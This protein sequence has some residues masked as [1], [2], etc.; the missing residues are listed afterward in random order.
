MLVRVADNDVV[1]LNESLLQEDEDIVGLECV[2]GDHSVTGAVVFDAEMR[3]LPLVSDYLSYS[4]RYNKISEATAKT[5]GRNLGYFLDFLM[6]NT[7]FDDELDG[8][9]LYVQQHVILDYIVYMKNSLGLASKTIRN[10]DA[11]LESFFNDYLCVARNNKPA[12]RIDNPYDEGLLSSAAKSKMPVMCGL[13]DVISLI[14]CSSLE[15]ER[16]L[17]QFMYDSGV[18]RSEVCRVTTQHINDALNFN[19][20][21]L[22]VDDTI[23]RIPSNYKPLHIE[24]AKGR[25]RE[26]KPRNTIVSNATL[27][28]V[29][30]Y[31]SSPLYKRFRRKFGNDSPVFL[32]AHGDKYTPSAISKLFNRLSAR[33]LKNLSLKVAIH[34]H[35]MRH[36]FAGSLLRSSDLG[37]DAVDRLVILQGCLGHYDMS[38]TNMYTSLPYDIYGALVSDD[39]AELCRYEIMEKIREI[40][41]IKIKLDDEK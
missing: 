30:R 35:M 14:R 20:Q 26:I 1:K 10:R 15:R 9:L 2:T 39:G 41:K 3:I 40:T 23:V 16:V 12:I 17:L 27:L 13:D 36:G 37:K 19:S 5:Y 4:L 28:R 29:K 21:N 22:I 25:K 33:G 38:T 34:P 18:R 31:I 8:S 32:N 7:I 6:R 24:G 11:T